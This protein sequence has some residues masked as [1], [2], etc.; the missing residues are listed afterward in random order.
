VTVERHD[1]PLDTRRP[2]TSYTRAALPKFIDWT[3]L[4]QAGPEPGHA[5]AAA[6]AWFSIRG[7]MQVFLRQ[8]RAKARC[9]RW[10]IVIARMA[11]AL[12]YSLI[13]AGALLVLAGLVAGALH[14]NAM[15][16]MAAM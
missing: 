8:R 7:L 13:G 14:R 12:A 6:G 2:G 1:K 9:S 3:D 11:F 15:H 4:D 16:S 5:A 10:S